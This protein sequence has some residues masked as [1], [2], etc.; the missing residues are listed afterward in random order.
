M[1]NSYLTTG[2][3]TTTGVLTVLSNTTMTGGDVTAVL[4]RFG[5]SG[6]H[7]GGCCCCCRLPD[8]KEQE[9]SREGRIG[10]CVVR[11][12]PNQVS[13]YYFCVQNRVEWGCSLIG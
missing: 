4:P 6:R 9:R 3:T 2:H 7:G 10:L 12:R 5:E 1:S 8:C 13:S 11:L